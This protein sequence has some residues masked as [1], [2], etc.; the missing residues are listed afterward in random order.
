MSHLFKEKLHQGK[1]VY[2]TA[3]TCAAPL[4]PATVKRAGLDFVFLDTEHMP[5][6]RAELAQMC[7]HYRALDIAPIVRISRPDPFQAC[8]A[9][10]AGA[11]GIVAPYIETVTELRDLVGATKFRPLKGERLQK[12]LQNPD[13]L[14]PELTSYIQNRNKDTLCIAN[15][16]SLPAL[17]NLDQLLA[18]PGLD[19][20]FVGPH[21]LSCSLGLPEKYDH[22]EFVRSVQS[23]MHKA[24]ANDLAIGIHFSES[25]QRQLFWVQQGMNIIIHSSDIALFGQRL[26]TDINT[27]KQELNDESI[28]TG[29]GPVI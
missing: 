13:E 7:Q 11:T 27:I 21:D 24:R 26:Q 9:L 19:G 17:H 18:V 25:P 6:N 4:W 15:I 8:I 2:G 22:P 20:I 1:R 10:D 16:E 3:I 5:L 28:Q 23:L 29:K 14:E 12:A